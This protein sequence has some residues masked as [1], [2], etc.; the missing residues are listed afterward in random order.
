MS[1]VAKVKPLHQAIILYRP[2]AVMQFR[3]HLLRKGH[4]QLVKSI[5]FLCASADPKDLLSL[6]MQAPLLEILPNLRSFSST[7]LIPIPGY[8]TLVLN[9]I[10]RYNRLV[11]HVELQEAGN[12]LV[13]EYDMALSL[14]RQFSLQSLHLAGKSSQPFGQPRNSFLFLQELA[15]RDR[16]F[17]RNQITPLVDSLPNSLSSLSF[18]YCNGLPS[19]FFA[20]IADRFRDLTILCLLHNN[21][22][23]L[24]SYSITGVEGKAANLHK[25]RNLALGLDAVTLVELVRINA[26]LA[27]V[28]L[29]RLYSLDASDFASLLAKWQCSKGEFNITV[30]PAGNWSKEEKVM[31]QV[32]IGSAEY[33]RLLIKLYSILLERDTR[34]LTFGEKV[35]LFLAR[36]YLLGSR[37]GACSKL[38][39]QLGSDVGLAR[40]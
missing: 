36:R 30:R 11:R 37:I 8:Q 39:I 34:T 38:K 26:P 4:A 1:R 18:I 25:L 16:T 17:G 32:R 6:A 24:E 15:I 31:L 14:V 19:N 3:E 2:S 22:D 27:R 28:L 9:K 10:I 33:A 40:L 12:G 5:T 7:P 13:W 21:T 20:L 35:R 29:D 23:D